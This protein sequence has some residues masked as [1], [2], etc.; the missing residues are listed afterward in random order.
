MVDLGYNYDNMSGAVI[1]LKPY[2][3]LKVTDVYKDIDY[4]LPYEAD[5]EEYMKSGKLDKRR[6]G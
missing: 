5:I 6:V 1:F 2:E 4:D 3:S